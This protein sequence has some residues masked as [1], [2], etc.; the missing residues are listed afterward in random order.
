L[1]I[2]FIQKLDNVL[3]AIKLPNIIKT[4]IF[5]ILLKIALKYLKK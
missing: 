5:V 4:T 2:V 1:L 3:Y